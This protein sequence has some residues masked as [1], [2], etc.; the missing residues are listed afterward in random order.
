LNN[1]GQSGH[2]C[3]IADFRRNSFSFSHLV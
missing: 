3:L 2:P 1:S